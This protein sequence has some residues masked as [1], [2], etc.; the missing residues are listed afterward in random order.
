MFQAR[1]GGIFGQFALDKVHLRTYSPPSEIHS[2]EW[3]ANPA[4]G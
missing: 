1:Q 2:K 4:R 3:I